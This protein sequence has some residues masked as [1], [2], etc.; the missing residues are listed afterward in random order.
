[1]KNLIRLLGIIAIVAVIGFSLVACGDAEQGP[2][3]PQGEQGEKG[4]PGGMIPYIPT[5]SGLLGT[6]WMV[7]DSDPI[8]ALAISYDGDTFYRIG[9]GSGTYQLL[10]YWKG[11]DG[12]ITIQLI[13]YSNYNMTVARIGINGNTLTW[14][15]SA[16]TKQ[17]ASVIP[18]ES[19]LRG[20]TWNRTD[21]TFSSAIITFSNDGLT[22]TTADTYQIAGY[23]KITNDSQLVFGQSLIYHFIISGNTMTYNTSTYTKEE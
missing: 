14:D 12:T 11:S 4:D 1:M 16:F 7:E 20:S 19:G 23:V 2:T 8:Q 6:F 5:E 22:V 9:T 15:D 17:G 21:G 13:R 3:G 10:S 18:A